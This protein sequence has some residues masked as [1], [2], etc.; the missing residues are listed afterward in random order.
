ME[1]MISNAINGSVQQTGYQYIKRRWEVVFFYLSYSC[2][3]LVRCLLVASTCRQNYN[4][5]IW[6]V[7]TSSMSDYKG[8]SKTSATRLDIFHGI[9][10]WF[11]MKGF[12]H[13]LSQVL[14]Y[15][16]TTLMVI[17]YYNITPMYIHNTL[18]PTYLF[19]LHRI[20]TT[21]WGTS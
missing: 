18:Y 4:K 6:C 15:D 3:W 1:W 7:C 2:T 13:F 9:V 16:M 11:H 17:I 19:I 8:C 21:D 12:S 14:W 5:Y 20:S 10:I